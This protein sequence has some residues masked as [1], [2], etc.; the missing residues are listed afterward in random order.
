LKLKKINFTKYYN[1]LKLLRKLTINLLSN[2]KGFRKLRWIIEK[3]YSFLKLKLK[4]GKVHTY[5]SKYVEK[6]IYMNAFLSNLL[7][8]YGGSDIDEFKVVF[9][10]WF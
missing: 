4:L 6:N 3:V 10:V 9:G 7:F 5:S 2:W 1:K 8:E